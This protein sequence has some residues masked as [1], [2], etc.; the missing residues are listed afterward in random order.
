MTLLENIYADINQEIADL[1][2]LIGD[3]GA[4]DFTHYKEL[5]GIKEGLTIALQKVHNIA[6]QL[7]A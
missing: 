3:G 4:S 7:D 5:V 6:K 2:V 1:T